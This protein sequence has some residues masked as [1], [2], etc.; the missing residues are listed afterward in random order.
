MSEFNLEF[1]VNN[2]ENKPNPIESMYKPT[3][4]TKDV[5]NIKNDFDILTLEEQEAILTFVEKINL[6]DTANITSYGKASQSKISDFSAQ[7]LN[8]V[9]LKDTGEV[10]ESLVKLM[11]E[12]NSIDEKEATGFM[13]LF[14]KAK[15]DVNVLMK[16]Y[17]SAEDT[18]NEISNKLDLQKIELLKD[19][20]ILDEMYENNKEYFK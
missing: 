17:S 5:E 3:V 7:V 13:K 2:S 11:S 18:I 15:N 1:D 10:G 20:E 8:E 4:T 16:N 6:S 12:I 9:K 19:I 14:K